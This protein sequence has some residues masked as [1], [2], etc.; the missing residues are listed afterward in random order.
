MQVQA[1]IVAHI[2]MANHRGHALVNPVMGDCPRGH[3]V[4]Q[5][6]TRRMLAIGSVTASGGDTGCGMIEVV[7]TRALHL[8]LD[9][10]VIEITIM[11]LGIEVTGMHHPDHLGRLMSVLIGITDEGRI[12]AGPHQT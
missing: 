11:R 12:E 1:F 7:T 4:G 9:L 8:V 3:R 6:G 10:I 2:Q 5:H